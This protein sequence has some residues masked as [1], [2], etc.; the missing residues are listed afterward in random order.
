MIE[1]QFEMSLKVPEFLE[2]VLTCDHLAKK[3]F[4]SIESV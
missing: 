1:I 3:I 4:E 2:R